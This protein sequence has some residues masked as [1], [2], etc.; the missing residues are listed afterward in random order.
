[1]RLVRCEGCGRHVRSEETRCPFCG[2]AR[3]A[4]VALEPVFRRVS[5]AAVFAGA[6]VVGGCWSSSKP[7]EE[8]PAF[9]VTET[10]PDPTEEKA[11]PPDEG[12][13]TI[14]GVVLDQDTQQPR[15]NLVVA[16]Y[17]V[18]DEGQ[19]PLATTT[20]DANGK[21]EFPTVKA[22]PYTVTVY[23]GPTPYRK[24]AVVKG[25]ATVMVAIHVMPVAQRRVPDPIAAPYGAPPSRRRVV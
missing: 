6:A 16:I 17:R 2:G 4:T 20:T 3:N 19:G 7:A 23:I 1:M 9:R 21:Y 12:T 11:P 14:T 13:G 15:P 5:R 22:G 8:P 24:A 18:R 10:P 25:G